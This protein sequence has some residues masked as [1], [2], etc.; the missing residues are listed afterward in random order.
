MF[1]EYALG[2]YYLSYCV[3][4]IVFIKMTPGKNQAFM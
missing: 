2:N 3:L 1:Y 4:R